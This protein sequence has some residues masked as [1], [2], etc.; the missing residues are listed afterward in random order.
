MHS[1]S[2]A[3]LKF[4]SPPWPSPYASGQASDAASAKRPAYAKDSVAALT[5]NS[6]KGQKA[7]LMLITER[8]FMVTWLSA[9]AAV[10]RSHAVTKDQRK[11]KAHAS[12][13][14]A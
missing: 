7:T 3:S 4:P 9:K 8:L 2:A 5:V 13:R 1:V 11:E 6:A 12:G 14:A 10:W